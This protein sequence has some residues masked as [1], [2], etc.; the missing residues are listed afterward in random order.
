MGELVRIDFQGDALWA[1]QQ[2]GEVMVAVKPICGA[3]G[4]NWDGQRQRIRRDAVLGATA[5]MITAVAADAKNREVLCL[6]LKYLNGWLFG[7]DAGRVKPEIREKV[8]AYQRECYDAL[9]RH[10]QP[11]VP[12]QLIVDADEGAGVTHAPFD[13]EPDDRGG[14]SASREQWRLG[15]ATVDMARVL[16]GPKAGLAKWSE[17]AALGHM[18][19]L[20]AGMPVPGMAGGWGVAAEPVSA[21]DA[22]ACLDHLLKAKPNGLPMPIGA[23]IAAIAE[24][25][26]HIAID[27]LHRALQRIG[28]RVMPPYPRF[29]GYTVAVANTALGVAQIF[30]PTRWRGLLWRRVLRAVET[31]RL[32]DGPMEIGGLKSRGVVIDLPIVLARWE[33]ISS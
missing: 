17:L 33:E 1:G 16:A 9:F 19:P 8:I 20:P 12:E 4:L 6:P 29:G 5:V 32:P 11:E 21:E 13:E 26:D 31:G 3:L 15:L 28:V 25:D 23:A 7:I 10:F 22:V 30:Q 27:Q 2:D 18:P 24:R 14:A